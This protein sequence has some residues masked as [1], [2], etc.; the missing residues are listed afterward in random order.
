LIEAEGAIESLKKEKSTAGGSSTREKELEKEMRRMKDE[1]EKERGRWEAAL[2]EREA[3]ARQAR[4]RER[5]NKAGE[6]D[7]EDARV[8][9]IFEQRHS[10]L[11]HLPSFCV[12]CRRK[13]R[14]YDRSLMV[15]AT[16]MRAFL[17]ARTI[18]KTDSTVLKLR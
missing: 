17:L 12:S 2:A 11:T 9:R 16:R 14:D 8:R 6:W 4:E 15:S 10:P 7:G 13:S 5:K 1:W 18:S 3:E